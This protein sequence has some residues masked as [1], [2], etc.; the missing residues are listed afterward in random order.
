MKKN[1]K[2]KNNKLENLYKSKDIIC[3]AKE[4]L[5]RYFSPH[6]KKKA[7]MLDLAVNDLFARAQTIHG[8]VLVPETILDDYIITNWANAWY[9]NIHE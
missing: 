2:N 4:G 9:E 5:T 1:E 8:R 6:A 3:S 7:H